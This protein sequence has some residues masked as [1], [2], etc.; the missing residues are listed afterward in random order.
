M[1]VPKCLYYLAVQTLIVNL[2]Q[3]NCRTCYWILK[4]PVC[5][6]NFCHYL[7]YR[8]FY[9]FII[10]L[11]F[12]IFIRE[13]LIEVK[14][15]NFFWFGNTLVWK[16]HFY[17]HIQ[18]QDFSCIADIMQVHTQTRNRYSCSSAPIEN[19]TQDRRIWM[20]TSLNVL[21]YKKFS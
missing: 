20:Q 9:I 11:H 3:I 16:K 5:W 14:I 10:F 18:Q 4:S 7:F 19:R 2:G 12:L 21:V 13:Y 8:D 6:R 1:L 17:T 15:A